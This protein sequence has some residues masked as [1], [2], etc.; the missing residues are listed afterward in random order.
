MSLTQFVDQPASQRIHAEAV[1]PVSNVGRSDPLGAAPVLGGV[2][3]S[4]Y[5]RDA[6]K[7]ELLLFDHEGD[8][9]PAR[10]IA[11]D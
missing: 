10:V 1:F 5:S 11:L 9:R 8:A 7:V 4:L 3:F 6:S 2:N